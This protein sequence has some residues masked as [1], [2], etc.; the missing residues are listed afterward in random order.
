MRLLRED[1]RGFVQLLPEVR[2]QGEIVI[3]PQNRNFF[4][5][6]YRA[7][8]RCSSSELAKHACCR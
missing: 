1:K 5:V 3:E 6:R 8:Q 2:A 7:P 4:Y